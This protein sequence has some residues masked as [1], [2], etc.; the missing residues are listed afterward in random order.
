MKLSFL[1]FFQEIFKK[2]SSLL[3]NLG[4][5]FLGKFVISSQRES[6][7]ILTAMQN[8]STTLGDFYLPSKSIKPYSIFLP[9]FPVTLL[10]DR[11]S[12]DSSD[13]SKI[14][15]TATENTRHSVTSTALLISQM[16][17]KN[18]T[19]FERHTRFEVNDLVFEE[20]WTY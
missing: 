5:E 18:L 6:F 13:E 4:D 9:E 3:P 11:I 16:T 10:H 8:S 19:P 15:L 17:L 12:L 1:V 7:N 14:V 20:H 2:Y